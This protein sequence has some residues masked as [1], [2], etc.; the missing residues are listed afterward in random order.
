MRTDRYRL[1]V[2]KDWT[3]PDAEPIFVELYDHQQDPHETV[4]IA[5]RE[6]VAVAR[7]LKTF[8]AGW[9]GVLPDRRDAR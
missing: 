9:R 5:E 6:P 1:V 4:N 2:W 3:L 7:L 8:R